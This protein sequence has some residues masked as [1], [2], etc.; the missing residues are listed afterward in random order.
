MNIRMVQAGDLDALLEMGASFYSIGKLPGRFEG[1]AFSSFWEGAVAS[2]QGAILIGEDDE[3]QVVGTLGALL[4]ADPNNGDIIAQELFWW[5]NEGHR[6]NGSLNLLK[7]YETWARGSGAKR[8][9]VSAVHGLK[10]ETLDKVY[11]RK[12]YR[13]IETNYVQDV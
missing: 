7:A 11:Q 9:V 3:G 12:G 10:E 2:G 6:G 13:P 5:V 1:S 4:Y 8:I